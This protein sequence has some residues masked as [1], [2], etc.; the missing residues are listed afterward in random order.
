MF[1]VKRP[2]DVLLQMLCTDTHRKGLG[3]EIHPLLFQGE[4]AVP[5]AVTDGQHR[6]V[7][8]QFFPV[9]LQAAQTVFPQQKALGLRLK[10]HLTPQFLHLLA[11]G[12]H[13]VLQQVGADVGFGSLQRLVGRA[14]LLQ[15]LQHQL[16]AIVPDTGGQLAVGI[17]ACATLAKLDVG[18]LVQL[19]AVKKG[20]DIPVT[21]IHGPA[22]LQNDGAVAVF[23]QRQS[24]ENAGGA[25]AHD[26]RRR[27]KLLFSGRGGH[28]GP[29]PQFD[30]G[31]V[32]FF[33]ER[34][35]V[36]GQRQLH[37]TDGFQVAVAQIERLFMQT[38][39]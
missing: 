18:P 14:M 28:D 11:H 17:S 7:A 20:L 8:G 15:Q 29:G 5:G 10:P 27:G 37:R 36:T 21:G 16:A 25:K 13:N 34:R 30:V 38:T 33:H 19:T 31:I 26:Y 1:T 22:T 3:L 24:G 23:R 32:A 6:H 9:Q 4:E 12:H 2:V 35:L 39:P